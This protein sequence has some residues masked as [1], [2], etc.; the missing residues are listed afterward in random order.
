M[1]ER[2]KSGATH[3]FRLSI[4]AS[5]LVDSM[6]P[7][8]SLEGRPY[9]RALG[10]KSALVSEAL[11]HYFGGEEGETIADLRKHNAWLIQQ[12]K[13]LER[14]NYGM[15]DAPPPHWWHRFWPF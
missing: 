4:P 8:V 12:V 13:G 1:K 2:R 7:F 15:D 6:P 10:G 3:S 14:L 9:P 5:D 11:L